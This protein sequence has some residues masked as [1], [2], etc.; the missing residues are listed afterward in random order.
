MTLY[1]SVQQQAQAE[2]S[3]VIGSDRLPT[4]R[5]WDSLPYVS[6]VVKEVL[7]WQPVTP[8]GNYSPY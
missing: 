2:I 4:L 6:A 1:P 5:D 8:Q 7:R 3:R